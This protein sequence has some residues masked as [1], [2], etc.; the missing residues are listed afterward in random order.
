M[1]RWKMCFLARRTSVKSFRFHCHLCWEKRMPACG[2]K[3][4]NFLASMVINQCYH[5]ICLSDDALHRQH[6]LGKLEFND[7][8]FRLTKTLKRYWVHHFIILIGIYMCPFYVFR[9]FFFFFGKTKK[10]LF[11]NVVSSIYLHFCSFACHLLARFSSNHPP[12]RPFVYVHPYCIFHFCL[13]PTF[14]SPF[15]SHFHC[16]VS[17]FSAII[18]ARL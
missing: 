11:L 16:I 8:D 9:F 4:G 6:P 12:A 1:V 7:E 13:L 14:F 3:N 15:E 10:G 2:L 17:H 18:S 5:L